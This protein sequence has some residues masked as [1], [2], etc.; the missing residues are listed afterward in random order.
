MPKPF[1]KIS[2]DEV[3]A[4]AERKLIE[5]MDTTKE[6]SALV[7]EHGLRWA[8]NILAEINSNHGHRFPEA[9][10]KIRA[11]LQL[12]YEA[13]SVIRFRGN[14]GKESNASTN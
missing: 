6:K 10:Q 9:A 12:L 14:K 2:S 3:Y 1:P 11:A 5:N 13:D 7:L 8:N 4:L